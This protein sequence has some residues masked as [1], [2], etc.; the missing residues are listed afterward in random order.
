[1]RC[2][3]APLLVAWLA[4]GCAA[5]PMGAV[6][7]DRWRDAETAAGES[8]DP[9]AVKLITYLRLISPNSGASAGE[10]ASWA[11]ANP[12]WPNQSQLEQRREEA[13]ANEAE[14][15]AAFEQCQHG[16]LRV[17]GALLR[18]AEAY[19]AAGRADEAARLVRQAWVT[20]I[21]DPNAEASFLKRWGAI[22]LASDQWARFQALAWSHPEAAARQIAR[23]DRGTQVVAEARLAFRRDDPAAETKLASNPALS[24]NPGLLLDR[25]AWLRRRDRL[26]EARDLWLLHGADLERDAPAERLAAC[27]SER[28]Q[29]ARR[30]LR[31]GEDRAAYTLVDRH[32]AVAPEQLLDAEFLAGF[33]ALRRLHDPAAAIPHFQAMGAASAAALTQSRSHYWLGRAEAEAGRSPEAEYRL[34]AP[35]LTTYYGQLAALALDPDLSALQ[36]RIR[37]ARDQAATREEALDVAGDEIARAAERLV[38]WGEPRRSHAF[39]LRLD[40]QTSSPERRALIAHLGNALG[41]P[42]VAVAIARRM[43]RDGLMLPQGGWPT[44]WTPPP[45]GP[46]P[47]IVLALMRQESSFDPEAVSPSGARGLMQLMPATAEAVSR[48][49]GQPSTLAALTEDPPTN[50]RLGTAYLSELV[51][52]FRSLPLALAAYNAGPHRVREWLDANGDPRSGGDMLDWIELIPFNET[53]NY[54]QRVLENAVIYRARAGDTTPVVLATSSAR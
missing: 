16:P 7:A 10:I 5:S 18:C 13:L 11:A 2:W 48:R 3:S 36:R 38:A 52:E 39:L 19:T 27:W 37:S 22:I 54:V 32:G 30:L 34:A 43:G 31:A 26:D 28:N 33:I 24:G 4:A 21:A 41:M 53:R 15:S 23:L 44:P 9:V 14:Q 50:M 8:A 17:T 35:W 12:T 42:D 47:A 40:E 46:D 1:M 45:T 25:L 51:A 20:G 6:R 49:T 29:L